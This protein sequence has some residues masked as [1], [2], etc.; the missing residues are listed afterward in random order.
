MRLLR[1]ILYVFGA[2]AIGW[3]VYWGGAALAL[4]WVVSDVQIGHGPGGVTWGFDPGAVGG[5]P[6]RFSMALGQPH[7][8]V[9]NGVRWESD[10]LGLSAASLAPHRLGVD[11]SQQHR[12]TGR[13]GALDVQSAQAEAIVLL[14]PQAHLPLETASFAFEA[15]SLR[16]AGGEGIDLA[17]LAVTVQVDAEAP[18]RLRVTAMLTGMDL[19]ALYPT[20]PERYQHV[21]DTQISADVISTAPLDIGLIAGGF[22]TVS[23]IERAEMRFTF[24]QTAVS[25]SGRVGFGPD[26]KAN[27]E[28]NITLQEWR[29]LIALL[30]EMELLEA[31]LEAFLIEQFEF[32][33]SQSEDPATLRLPIVISE[34]FVMFGM[35]RLGFIPSIE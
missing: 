20:L 19:A 7:F 25:L 13:F 18:T 17:A 9:A 27:G 2:V 34:G 8:E 10:G 12:F 4:R 11:L 26:G 32:L 24:G 33:A 1:A 30:I 31:G 15:M 35:Y 3:T 21:P 6:T 29:P 14:R 28:V 5:Y 16:G 22:P 23:H